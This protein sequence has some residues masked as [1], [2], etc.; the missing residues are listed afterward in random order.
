M[1]KTS[2]TIIPGII[3]RLLLP[4]APALPT[5]RSHPC[6]PVAPD[7]RGS[8]F[9]RPCHLPL[10][11]LLLLSLL[12]FL[13]LPLTAQSEEKTLLIESI[14]FEGNTKT[15]ASVIRNY[16]TLKEGQPVTREELEKDQSRLQQTNFF[17]EVQLLLQPGSER[18]RALLVV[19][20][21]ERRWPYLQFESGYNE[22]DGWYISP[23][24]VRFD[25]LFGGGHFFGGELVIGDRIA[26]GRVDFIK[27]FLW[28][29]EYD[30]QAQFFVSS[31]EFVHFIPQENSGSQDKFKQ[32]VGGG[33]LMLRLAGN[34]GIPKLFSLAYIAQTVEADS[35]LT[36]GSDKSQHYDAPEYLLEAAGKKDLRRFVFAFTV[37]TRNRKGNPSSGW[38]GSL[39]YDQSSRDLGSFANF[40]RVIGDIRRYQHL[41]KGVSG[42]VRLK[43]GR[44]SEA[45]PFYEKFYLGGPNSLRGYADRSLTPPGYASYLTQ[46]SAELRFPLSARPKNRDRLIGV[47]FYDVG[48][49]W[50]K[51]DSWEFERLKAGMGFGV[52]L[53]LPI[54]GLL[55]MDFAYPVP[56]YEFRFHLSLGH[57]F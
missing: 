12:L 7:G 25:N 50:N 29:S 17:K 9:N 51:P 28:G 35:F 13:P 18:G 46:G 6:S 2:R 15:K 10:S 20:V 5:I 31:R 19:S 33:G 40:Y 1:K 47:L 42:A 14:Q 8:R 43:G 3:A 16:L 36:Q 48:Y 53:K 38:W 21:Q 11:L 37:D 56:E 49:A 26:A 39:S 54:V 57:T 23:L 52:R 30:F 44:V 55:R 34:S 4:P 22:L 27:P 32:Q 41:W 45:A 24:G